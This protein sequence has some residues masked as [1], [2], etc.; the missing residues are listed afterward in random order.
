MA[1]YLLERLHGIFQYNNDSRGGILTSELNGMTSFKV[2]GVNTMS[3]KVWFSK[4]HGS[5]YLAQ[6][7]SSNIGNGML[8]SFQQRPPLC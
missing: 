6:R 8:S 7:K 5:A 2:F 1:L 3:L 4:Q